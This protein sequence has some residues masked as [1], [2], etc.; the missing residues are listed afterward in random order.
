MDI[1]TQVETLFRQHGDDAY[2]GESVSQREHALQA[3]HLAE[4]EGAPDSLVVAALLHD[5]G[6][7][8]HGLDEQIAD[9]GIDGRHEAVGEAWLRE[10][11]G[12]EVTEPVRL[13]V[14]AKRYLCAV[15]PDYRAHL[16]PAS[17]LSLDLQGGCF[18]ADEATAFEANPFAEA[19]TRLRRWDDAAKTPARDVPGVEHYRERLRAAVRDERI[20]A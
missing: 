18:S 19:A 11:F 13:H 6:H 1:C 16:S 14:A 10:W 9:R 4:N 5:V 7:L 3:A 2:F 20:L 12:P 17:Q 15:D 8:L